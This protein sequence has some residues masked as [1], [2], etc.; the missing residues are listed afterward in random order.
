M[1]AVVL[2]LSH[3]VSVKRNLL[4]HQR[5]PTSHFMIIKPRKH[6]WSEKRMARFIWKVHDRANSFVL[7][8]TLCMI[9]SVGQNVIPPSKHQRDRL[10]LESPN[11]PVSKDRLSHVLRLREN[12]S[13]ETARKN[14][15]IL[16]SQ[17][18]N[19]SAGFGCHVIKRFITHVHCSCCALYL[20]S[21]PILCDSTPLFRRV[22]DKALGRRWI[23]ELLLELL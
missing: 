9:S 20:Q 19:H 23:T 14:T 13:C 1:L 5:Q 11:R 17:V 6:H 4:A 12:F 2:N 22:E 21:V 16:P 18:A 15:V 10:S 8:H 7:R 3:G